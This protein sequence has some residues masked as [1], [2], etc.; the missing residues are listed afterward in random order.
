M[1]EE[2]F[3]AL[4]RELE[5]EKDMLREWGEKECAL[6]REER[7][8]TRE[9]EQA[10]ESSQRQRQLQEQELKILELELRLRGSMGRESTVVSEPGGTYHERSACTGSV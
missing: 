7:A 10:K 8:R 9:R 3:F 5:L 6:A 1:D 2:R 4:G